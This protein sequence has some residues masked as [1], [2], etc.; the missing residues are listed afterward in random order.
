MNQDLRSWYWIFLNS[1]KGE[2]TRH[3]PLAFLRLS[4]CVA[5]RGKNEWCG[6]FCY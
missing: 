5:S 2:L 1:P 3:S 6:M 4:L